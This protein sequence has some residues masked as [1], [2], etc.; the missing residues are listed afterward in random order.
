MTGKQSHDQSV[1]KL[2]YGMLMSGPGVTTEG[3][4]SATIK[5]TENSLS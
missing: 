2:V 1:I 5:P 3:R 4:E